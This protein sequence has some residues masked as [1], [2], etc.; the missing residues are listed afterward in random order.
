M[1]TALVR[2]AAILVILMP[3]AC[4]P[5]A[6]RSS[7]RTDLI[8]QE[9]L[10]RGHFRNAYEAVQALHANWLLSRGPDSAQRPTEVIVYEDLMRLGGVNTLRG[11]TILGIKYIQ[12]FN[13]QEATARWGLDHGQGAILVSTR[14]R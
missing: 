1:R 3:L 6:A 10:E 2:L 8:T 9:E 4:A 13:G 12:H 5:G 11:I 7:V 14:S